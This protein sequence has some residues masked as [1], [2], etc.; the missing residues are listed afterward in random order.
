MNAK[1]IITILL[2]MLSPASI[3]AQNLSV[4]VNLWYAWF[5][6]SFKNE[7]MG[8]NDSATYNN[9]FSMTQKSVFTPAGMISYKL[10]D[11][12]VLASVIGYGKGYKCESEY[13]F[14]HPLYG[15]FHMHKA[16]DTLSRLEADANLSYTLNSYFKVF[17]GV[18]YSLVTGDGTYNYYR[19]LDPT[20]PVFQGN[21]TFDIAAHQ[22]GPGLGIGNSLNVLGDLYFVTTLSGLYQYE[23]M[24]KETKGSKNETLNTTSNNFGL[25][26]TASLAYVFLDEGLT[27]SLGGRYQQLWR[28]SVGT[29]YRFYGM[30]L[31]VVYSF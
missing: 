27:L 18:K 14:T 24:T 2:I 1:L 6:P 22:V 17:G 30:M 4:G 16:F 31:S 19:I 15:E 5:E 9:E 7:F 10:S 28:T 25:N 23:K 12:W 20:N 29:N 8:K 21:G 11:R 26:T 3:Y 13:D